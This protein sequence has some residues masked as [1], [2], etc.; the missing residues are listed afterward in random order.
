MLGVR[1]EPQLEAQLQRVARQRR[2]NKSEL[3]RE[4]VRQFVR[5]HDEAWRAECIRQ[6]LVVADEGDD[7]FWEA[8]SEESIAGTEPH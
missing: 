4:A 7:G 3:V 1:L 5:Q 6:S 2:Q 8:L